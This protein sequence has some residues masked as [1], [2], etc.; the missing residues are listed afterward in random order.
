M[1]T[2][3]PSYSASPVSIQVQ[4]NGCCIVLALMTADGSVNIIE[5]LHVLDSVKSKIV[6]HVLPLFVELL[7]HHSHSNQNVTLKA[8]EALRELSTDSKHCFIFIH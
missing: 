1:Y 3:S 8:A 5:C 2:S 7:A 4:M 6:Q